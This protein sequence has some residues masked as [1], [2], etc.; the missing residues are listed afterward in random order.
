MAWVGE[1]VSTSSSL[2]GIFT[3]MEWGSVTQEVW[4][5][6]SPSLRGDRMWPGS[7]QE[8][9]EEG[10][11]ENSPMP[12]SGASHLSASAVGTV[13]TVLWGWATRQS[14]LAELLEGPVA[15]QKAA[16]V[17]KS[18]PWMRM[19]CRVAVLSVTQLMPFSASPCFS[20]C[21]DRD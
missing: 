19:G 21:S 2:L 11:E 4:V 17:L 9:Q 1:S 8:L 15:S 10:R 20:V 13:D 12:S 3:W 16:G 14:F 7:S 6:Q 5:A 18:R